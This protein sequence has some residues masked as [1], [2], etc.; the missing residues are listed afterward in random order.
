M[1]AYFKVEDVTYPLIEVSI[2]DMNE[3]LKNDLYALPS[4]FDKNKRIWPKS[5][6][7][8]VVFRE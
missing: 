8:V 6:V 3:L 4:Y 7:L 2:E 1:K 5:D